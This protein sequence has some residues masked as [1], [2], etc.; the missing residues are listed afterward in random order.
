MKKV[1]VVE[2]QGKWVNIETAVFKRQ[3]EGMKQLRYLT[4]HLWCF[5]YQ[6]QFGDNVFKQ[7]I[8]NWLRVAA[9]VRKYSCHFRFFEKNNCFY[10][11]LKKIIKQKMFSI[12]LFLVLEFFDITEVIYTGKIKTILH[13]HIYFTEFK[14]VYRGKIQNL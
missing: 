12:F 4:W 13:I 2:F 5:H 11:F 9:G 1:R 8:S 3:E 14:V 6:D 10:F 7:S